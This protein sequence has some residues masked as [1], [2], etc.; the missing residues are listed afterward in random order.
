[1]N[2]RNL[3]ITLMVWAVLI[4]GCGPS[5]ADSPSLE[6][7]PWVLV[8]LEGKL[9]LTGT[10]PSAEFSADQIIGSA[11]CS[12][13]VGTYAVSGSSITISDVGSTERYCMEPEGVMEQEPT[14]LAALASAAGYRLAGVRLELL[15]AT[16]SVILAF[17]PAP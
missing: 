17:E 2:S 10:A 1:M 12:H 14:F 4:A 15:D 8:M 5:P 9:P 7:M 11:G 16:G 3:T 6:G 13:Y